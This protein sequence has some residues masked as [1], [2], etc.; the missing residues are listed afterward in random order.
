MTIRPLAIILA[1]VLAACTPQQQATTTNAITQAQT[2]AEQ[3]QQAVQMAIQLWGVAKGI[4]LV[5]EVAQPSL[6]PAVNAVI[7]AVDPKVATAQ[8]A[9]DMASTDV[10]LMVSMAQQIKD[11]AAALTT[12]AAPAVKV[13]AAR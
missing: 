4:A 3:A 7:A 12:T 13:V 6:A 8:K 9:L 11:Q 5:A 2:T 1:T 10:S